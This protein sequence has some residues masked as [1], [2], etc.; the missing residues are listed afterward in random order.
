M[1]AG[2]GR[3]DYVW[4]RILLPVVSLVGAD[5]PIWVAVMLGLLQWPLYGLLLSLYRMQWQVWV[6]L[7]V[8][9]AAMVLLLFG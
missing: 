2:M 8:A 6:V 9:H 1:S 5:P 4:A 3:G 7:L